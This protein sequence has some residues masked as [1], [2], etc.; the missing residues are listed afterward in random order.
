LASFNDTLYNSE[1]CI[2]QARKFSEERFK[3]EIEK[4]IA[5][6]QAPYFGESR[7]RSN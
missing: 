2:K 4:I 6:S 7:R 5:G 1:D 3:K